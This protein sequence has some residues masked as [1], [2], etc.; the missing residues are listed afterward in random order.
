[1]ATAAPEKRFEIP[2]GKSPDGSY[3]VELESSVRGAVSAAT[4]SKV[5]LVVVPVV[6]TMYFLSSLVSLVLQYA[7][8]CGSHGNM[9]S[10][11]PPSPQDRNN[12]GNARIAG[13]QDDLHLSDT[14][15]GV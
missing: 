15:V 3:T 10:L 6:T 9:G 12:I 8:L 2:E 13:F 4:W 11:G 1:M 7:H 5:D 14:Q